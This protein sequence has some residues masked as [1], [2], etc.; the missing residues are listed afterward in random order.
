MQ[1]QCVPLKPFSQNKARKGCQFKTKACADFM[2]SL[3]I[4][5][6]SQPK[7]D[8]PTEGDLEIHFLWGLSNYRLSDYDNPIKTAQDAI[9]THYGINDNQF[10]AGSQRKVKVQKG[11]EFIRF[12]ICTHNPE[13]WRGL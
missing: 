5:L 9:C 8:F 6:L 12:S 4:Y 11:A 10:V 3:R 13:A 7:V 2:Y 1:S